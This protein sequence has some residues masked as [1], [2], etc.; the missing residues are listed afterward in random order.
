MKNLI[1]MC[2]VGMSLVFGACAHKNCGGCKDGSCKM[3]KK[4]HKD[5]G[6]DHKHDDAAKK[7]EEKK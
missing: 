2:V 6:C 7:P 4:D 3:E 5:C 1:L